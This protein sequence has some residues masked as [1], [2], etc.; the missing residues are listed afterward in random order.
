MEL[1]LSFSVSPKRGNS[2]WAMVDPLLKLL[3]LQDHT[4][5]DAARTRSFFISVR[6]YSELK[7]NK[8]SVRKQH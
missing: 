4:V 2:F 3:V 8:S 7:K 5:I 6:S 1:S